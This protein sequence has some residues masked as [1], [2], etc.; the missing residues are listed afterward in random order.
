MPE[1]IAPET[2]FLNVQSFCLAI[3]N[4]VSLSH[5]SYICDRNWWQ[6]TFKL[7]LIADQEICKCIYLILRWNY[8]E[9][10]LREKLLCA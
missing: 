3:Q 10:Q 5:N 9:S 7:C 1:V 4:S 2:G 8:D 6:Q